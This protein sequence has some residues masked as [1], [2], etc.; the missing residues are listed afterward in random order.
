MAPGAEVAPAAGRDATGAELDEVPGWREH[1]LP[2]IS[3]DTRS[4]AQATEAVLVTKPPRGMAMRTSV[5]RRLDR[6]G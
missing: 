1:A 6:H 2:A 5:E 4:Q 3:A